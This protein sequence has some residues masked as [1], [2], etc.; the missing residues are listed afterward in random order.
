MYMYIR[1]VCILLQQKKLSIEVQKLKKEQ[2][3]T[4]NTCY[5]KNKH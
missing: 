5:S 3:Q 1:N 4:K 2:Q